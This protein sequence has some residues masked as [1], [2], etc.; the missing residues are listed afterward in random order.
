M[1]AALLRMIL[2]TFASTVAHYEAW[3]ASYDEYPA[4]GLVGSRGPLP[5]AEDRVCRGLVS[6]LAFCLESHRGP[7]VLLRLVNS[8][9]SVKM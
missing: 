7:V 4:Q 3:L 1:D 5:W 9:A 6:G 8:W 2:R